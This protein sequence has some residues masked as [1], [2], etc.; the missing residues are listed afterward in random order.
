MNRKGILAAV[1]TFIT[2]IGAPSVMAQTTYCTEPIVGGVI[3][4]DVV[5]PAGQSC[6]LD[7]TLV[8]GSVTVLSNASLDADNAIIGADV[9]GQGAA[10]I[11]LF[12]S[13]AINVQVDHG[14]GSFYIV[15]SFISGDVTFDHTSAYCNTSPDLAC[16]EVMSNT[17]AGSVT[18]QN[19]SASCPC[20][21]SSGDPG[22]GLGLGL[23]DLLPGTLDDTQCH[24][25]RI[26]QNIDIGGD[27]I[28]YGNC[29][30][31]II[32]DNPIGGDLVFQCNQGK[33]H[34]LRN[35]I[36]GDLVVSNNSPAPEVADNVLLPL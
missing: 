7:D 2:L 9:I 26:E 22:L 8:S 29:G 13:D 5:V 30:T 16:F 3:V 10:H 21:G 18:V 1:A 36:A 11:S 20:G 19:S 35:I 17:I 12:E 31:S 23:G 27:L 34:I 28:F 33:G 24:A 32:S 4:G 15:S 6:E 14:S 25:F